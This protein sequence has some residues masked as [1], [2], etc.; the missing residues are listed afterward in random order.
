MPIARN[1]KTTVDPDAIAAFGAAADALPSEAR[2]AATPKSQAKAPSPAAG[3]A[4]LTAL[5]R[6]RGHEELRDRIAD[7]NK[8]TRYPNHAIMLRAMEIGMEYIEK[9]GME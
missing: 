8:A 6:W 7:Y 4:P 2:E 5:V 3:D 9:H 1:K